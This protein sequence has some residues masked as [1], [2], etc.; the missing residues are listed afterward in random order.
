MTSFNRFAHSLENGL[1]IYLLNSNKIKEVEDFI[2]A[3]VEREEIR[4]DREYI[5][6]NEGRIHCKEFLA[7]YFGWNCSI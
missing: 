2:N 5:L 4:M 6:S 7:S 3:V 1:T